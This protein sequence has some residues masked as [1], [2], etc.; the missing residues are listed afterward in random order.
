MKELFFELSPRGIREYELTG[1]KW[2]KRNLGHYAVILLNEFTQN[3]A[4]TSS[5]V[6][7]TGYT[8]ES[9]IVAY[10]YPLVLIGIYL[11]GGRRWKEMFNL[12]RGEDIQIEQYLDGTYPRLWNT[13]KSLE[14]LPYY[15][16]IRG[17]KAFGWYVKVKNIL[18]AALSELIFA[19]MYGIKKPFKVCKKHLAFYYD[20]CPYCKPEKDLK[21]RFSNLLRQHKY[22]ILNDVFPLEEGIKDYLVS[23]IERISRLKSLSRA[24]KE[25]YDLCRENGL[26]TEWYENFKN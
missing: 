17:V 1:E 5:L 3:E 9:E 20:A 25:Y 10:V 4:V 6:E 11:A 12:P 22:R 15:T 21:K 19:F 14:V 23:E 26:P 18:E 24:V 8:T 2:K 7:M 13:W 16:E